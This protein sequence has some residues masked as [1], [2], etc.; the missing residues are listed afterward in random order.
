MDR[1]PD[2]DGGRRVARQHGA[3]QGGVKQYRSPALDALLPLA[4]RAFGDRAESVL[5]EIT[6]QF[7]ARCAKLGLA[8]QE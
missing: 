5:A 6:A 8:V 1:C 7:N 2:Q 4:N 3:A